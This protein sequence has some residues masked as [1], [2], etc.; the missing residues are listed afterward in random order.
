MSSIVHKLHTRCK[1]TVTYSVFCL[2]IHHRICIFPAKTL[3]MLM[4]LGQNVSSKPLSIFTAL[5]STGLE[6]AF[7]SVA[8]FDHFRM[9]LTF[10]DEST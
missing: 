6:A 8:F 9:F 7:S 3:L 1:N 4:M 10:F 5:F 2:V